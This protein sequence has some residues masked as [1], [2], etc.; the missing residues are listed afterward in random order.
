MDDDHSDSDGD[1]HT[2]PPSSSLGKKRAREDDDFADSDDV[3]LE[4]PAP[5]KSGVTVNG[6]YTYP[7]F[8]RAF[9]PLLISC[10]YMQWLEYQWTSVT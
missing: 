10:I 1:K 2:R 5:A 8:P 4:P 7:S 6:K 9:L 3:A